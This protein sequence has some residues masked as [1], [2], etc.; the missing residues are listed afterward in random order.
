LFKVLL[1]T[2]FTL[3]GKFNF[4]YQ[5]QPQVILTG[6]FAGDALSNVGAT[7]FDVPIEGSGNFTAAVP[8]PGTYAM[9]IAGLLGIVGVSRRRFK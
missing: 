3:P 4:E 6:V 9:L 8:E 1:D 5:S 7:Q 2:T